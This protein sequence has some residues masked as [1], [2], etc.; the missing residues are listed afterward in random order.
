MSEAV[1]SARNR[2]AVWFLSSHVF[3]SLRA[4]DTLLATCLSTCTAPALDSPDSTTHRQRFVMQQVG[5]GSGAALY[6][7]NSAGSATTSSASGASNVGGASGG[8]GSGNNYVSSGGD[9]AKCV[10]LLNGAQIVHAELQIKIRKHPNSIHKTSVGPDRSWLL[11]QIQDATNL[12]IEARHWL[13]RALDLERQIQ[14]QQSAD[15]FDWSPEFQR[16]ISHRLDNILQ[17]IMMRLRRGRDCLLTPRKKTIEDHLGSENM[18]AL[19]P[20]LPSDIAISFYVQGE[21]LM[22]AIYHLVSRQ[23]SVRFES[24]LAET[25]PPRL[26]SMLACFSHT[27]QLVRQIKHNHYWSQRC[28]SDEISAVTYPFQSADC[29]S[30]GVLSPGLAENAPAP[31]GVSH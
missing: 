8:G 25:R 10:V 21:R 2:E 29:A 17:Q 13:G 27:L 3:S 28:H 11:P 7:G 1:T 31:V 19:T 23:G 14:Q 26:A 16:Y 22:L 30:A 4:L 24:F 12:L 18:R 15:G 5:C 9:T 20:L 6:S